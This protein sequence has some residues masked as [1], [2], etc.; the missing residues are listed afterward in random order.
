MVIAG[1]VCFLWAD[2]W[3]EKSAQSEAALGALLTLYSVVLAAHVGNLMIFWRIVRNP[4]EVSGEVTLS[5]KYLLAMSR[6]R[7]LLAIF[8]V[9]MAAWYDSFTLSLGWAWG[10][11]LVQRHPG[12]LGLELP[13]EAKP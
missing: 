10:A 11:G 8:P 3:T 9:G 12:H 6:S 5:H 13:A 7:S 4:D 1:F 2:G